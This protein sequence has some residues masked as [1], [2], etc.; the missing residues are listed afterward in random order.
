MSPSLIHEADHYG[1]TFNSGGDLLQAAQI[2]L[3]E[4]G[5]EQQILRRIATYSELGE[6][7]QVYPEL[8]RL[9]YRLQDSLGVAGQISH[10][11]IDLGQSKAQRWQSIPPSAG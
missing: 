10:G 11:G 8:L 9:I 3:D 4:T 6:C 7:Y 5:H 2:V 1:D